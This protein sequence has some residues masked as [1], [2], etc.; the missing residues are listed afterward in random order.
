MDII[1]RSRDL[2][3]AL[4]LTQ[5]GTNAQTS[6][7]TGVGMNTL[8]EAHKG[9]LTI[10]TTDLRVSIRTEI[11]VT[12][13]RE[14]RASLL[15]ALLQRVA[16]A[17]PEPMTEIGMTGNRATLVC[18]TIRATMYGERPEDYPA[19]RLTKGRGKVGATIRTSRLLSAIQNAAAG[20]GS[21][22]N[23]PQAGANAKLEIGDA[24]MRITTNIGSRAGVAELQLTDGQT[25][26]ATTCVVPV[27]GL[28]KAVPVL[29]ADSGEAWIEI[30]DDDGHVYIETE[31]S[32]TAIKTATN[33]RILPDPEIPEPARSDT[34][35]TVKTTQFRAA[36][37]A[38]EAFAKEGPERAEIAATRARRGNRELSIRV[39]DD[40]LGE[41]RD[42][43]HGTQARGPEAKIQVDTAQ[44][45]QISRL[46]PGEH[47]EMVIR[48]EYGPVTFR[49]NEEGDLMTHLTMPW[50]D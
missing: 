37:D 45:R 30:N 40:L 27:R 13:R 19:L 28:V 18:G 23:Q 26:R 1:C 36:V 47:I 32:G 44:L 5:G 6:L 42:R 11:D 35:T 29:Q 8:L 46:A 49:S 25:R 22:G 10:S 4:R 39:R 16:A 48:G 20:A 17:M 33:A 3:R 50:T 24:A 43:L 2:E 9:K 15:H 12:V 31:R 34:K 14:G 38:S 41:I 21:E 7:R